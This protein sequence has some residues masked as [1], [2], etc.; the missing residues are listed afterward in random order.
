MLGRTDNFR[1]TFFQIN[2]GEK[3]LSIDIIDFY[4]HI[5]NEI[6]DGKL[7]DILVKGYYKFNYWYYTT[8]HLILHK[9][10]QLFTLIDMDNFM[11]TG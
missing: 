5:L 2:F 1:P 9:I 8:Q 11:E 10:N 4:Q 6:N 7:L 3:I